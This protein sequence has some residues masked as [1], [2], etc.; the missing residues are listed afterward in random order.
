MNTIHRFAERKATD[1]SLHEYYKRFA[2]RNVTEFTH[3][4][5]L[6]QIKERTMEVVR[7]GSCE[8]AATIPSTNN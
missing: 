8:K 3:S 6:D 4:K 1:Y 5:T 7:Q 2:E